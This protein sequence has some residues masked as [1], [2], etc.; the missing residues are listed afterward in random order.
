MN[1]NKGQRLGPK[2]T[3]SLESISSL[4]YR[5]AEPRMLTVCP[6][7]STV[8]IFRGFCCLH[9][10]EGSI[11]HA[12]TPIQDERRKKSLRGKREG[13]VWELKKVQKQKHCVDKRLWALR[14]AP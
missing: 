5:E 13:P 3:K 6:T 10:G 8:S 1:E 11:I 14:S 2:K 9:L 4:N 7:T 12:D